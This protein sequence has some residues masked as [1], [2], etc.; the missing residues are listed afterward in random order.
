MRQ[1]AVSGNVSTEE[2]RELYGRRVDQAHLLK[3]QRC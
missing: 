2:L 1:Y 3:S